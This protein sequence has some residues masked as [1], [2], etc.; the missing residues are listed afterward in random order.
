MDS[1]MDHVIVNMN[2][3][4]P[5]INPNEDATKPLVVSGFETLKNILRSFRKVKIL[6]DDAELVI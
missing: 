1:Q 2:G 5:E 6:F 4:E 3:Y